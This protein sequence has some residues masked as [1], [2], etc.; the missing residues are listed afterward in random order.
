[1]LWR[2][3]ISA[4]AM[5]ARSSFATSIAPE[6]P[7]S[8][9][10]TMPGRSTPPAVDSGTPNASSRFTRVPVRLEAV[11]WVIKPA[12][13]DTTMRW[14]SSN[15]TASG[16]GSGSRS[17]ATRSW[18]S[19]VSPPATWNDLARSRPSTSNR[20]S[21]MAR[22]TSARGI[23]NPPAATV[24]RRP[25]PG[26]SNETRSMSRFGLGPPAQPGQGNDERADD[27]GGVGRVEHRPHPEVDEI[28]HAAGP[29]DDAVRE[30][31]Q[32][33]AQYEP[34]PDGGHSRLERG[35]SHHD[36]RAHDRGRSKEQ[37]RLPSEQA[38]GPPGV[39]G[40]AQSDHSRDDVDGGPPRESQ[41]DH[42]LRH[43]IDGVDP[44]G[45]R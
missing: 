29:S 44:G 11:P 14:S 12:G 21:A 25:G 17:P 41:L 31:A 26:A 18:T 32:R 39:R 45:G 7:A 28:D 27:D 24:S 6:V 19:I 13:L 15:R 43:A 40:K 33:S 3:N 20:P 2:R 9:R 36:D 35:G 37:P 16:P 8:S 30:V 1:M 4:R 22:C 42:P 10:C 5:C 23:P 38:E 34:E